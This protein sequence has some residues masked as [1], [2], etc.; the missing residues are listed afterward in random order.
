M[1]NSSGQSL[2]E[3][4]VVL[5]MVTVLVTSIVAGSTVSLRNQQASKLRDTALA[6][7]QKGLEL[8]RTLKNSD[9]D[10]FVEYAGSFCLDADGTYTR[11]VDSCESL[12]DDTYTRVVT[13]TWDAANERMAVDMVV[14]WTAS[15][16]T[17]TTKL[18]TYYT[19]WK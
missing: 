6:Y 13:F 16:K 14:S 3:M 11:Y 18:D 5:G 2:L 10:T 8:V 17:Y 1:K 19:N 9:W 4:L 15:T 7:A 12:L